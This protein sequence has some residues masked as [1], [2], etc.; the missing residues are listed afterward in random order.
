MF[1]HLFLSVNFSYNLTLY[2]RNIIT[3]MY[4]KNRTVRCATYLRKTKY[5]PF[6]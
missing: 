2:N 4:K 3:H 1:G 6:W 5:K